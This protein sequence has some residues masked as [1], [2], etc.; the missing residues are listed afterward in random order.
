MVLLDGIDHRTRAAAIVRELVEEGDHGAGSM[1]VSLYDTA[2]VSMVSRSVHGKQEW[3]YPEAFEY[4]LRTQDQ[5]GGWHTSPFAIDS[6]LNTLAALLALCR[7]IAEADSP[8]ESIKESLFHRRNRTIY[9]LD[10]RLCQWNIEATVSDG[11]EIIVPKLL[12]LLSAEGIDFNFPGLDTLYE[13]RDTSLESFDPSLLYNTVR[14]PFAQYLE[15]LIG[16]VDFDQIMQ[17]RISGSM[18]GSPAATAA[19]L[20]N[21]TIWDSEAEAYLDGALAAADYDIP[22]KVPALFPANI[23]EVSSSLSTLLS[24]GLD[25]SHLGEGCIQ[26]L[27][28]LLEVCL[29]IEG[30]VIGVAPNLEPEAGITAKVLSTLCLLGR[31]PSAEGLIAKFDAGDHFK[32]KA[33]DLKPGFSTNCLVLKAFLELVPDCSQSERIEK[34]VRYIEHYWW[35]TNGQIEETTNLSP[36]YPTMLMVDAFTHLVDLW[37]KDQ[38]PFTHNLAVKDKVIICLYQALTRVLQIQNLDGSWGCG[39]RC[40]TTAYAI[41]TLAKLSGTSSAPSVRTQITHAIEA[42]RHFLVQNF[43]DATEPEHIWCGKTTAGSRIVS[44]AHIIAALEA[45]VSMHISRSVEIMYQMPLAKLAVHTKYFA[46]QPWFAHMQ[47]WQVQA[48]LVQSQLFLPQLKSIRHVIFPKESVQE[49]RYFETIPFVW[50]AT[51]IYRQRLVAPEYLYQMMTL[52]FLNRQLSDYL[53]HHA[54][55]TFAGC[56]SELED[57][58]HRIFEH[59]ELSEGRDGYYDSFDPSSMRSSTST[60]M[61]TALSEVHTILS[62]FVAHT[63]DH[64]YVVMA[65]ITDQAKLRSELLAFLIGKLHRES[66]KSSAASPSSDVDLSGDQT[67]HNY[68]FA[69]LSCLVGNQRASGTQ[70]APLDFLETPEQQYLASAMCKHISVINFLSSNA[71]ERSAVTRG[72]SPRPTTPG[73]QWSWNRRGQNSSISSMSTTSTYSNGGVSPASVLSSNSSAPPSVSPMS[74]HF[75]TNRSSPNS[76]SNALQFLRLLIHERRCLDVCLQDLNAAAICSRTANVIGLFSDVSDLASQVFC[77]PNIGSFQQPMTA[78]EVIEQACNLQPAPVR[79]KRSVRKGSVG[80]ARAGLT[81]E[82]PKPKHEITIKQAPPIEPPVVKI[83]VPKLNMPESKHEVPDNQTHQKPPALRD[84]PKQK[85][86]K[87]KKQ[88]MHPRFTSLQDAEYPQPRSAPATQQSFELDPSFPVPHIDPSRN[89]IEMSRIEKIMSEM[90]EGDK[91]NST[92]SSGATLKTKD[93]SHHSPQTRGRAATTGE[94]IYM[95]PS[96]RNLEAQRRLHSAPTL[97]SP[98]SEGIRMAKAR[99]HIQRNICKELDKQLEDNRKALEK[100]KQAETQRRPTGSQPQ[101]RL[102]TVKIVPTIT[103]S[104][105]PKAKVKK[106]EIQRVR[107]VGDEDEK[108]LEANGWIKSPPPE[109]PGVSFMDFDLDEE[110]RRRGKLRRKRSG[111]PKLK[112]PF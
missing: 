92:P 12:E 9:Y 44:Q 55:G 37:D 67:H 16:D 109:K 51:N 19:Y 84:P 102:S 42:G 33:E 107:F 31:A 82:V 79:S 7:H 57:I 29:S 36:T 56:L 39:R 93:G 87:Q 88:V 66:D 103:R 15:G 32:N 23:F 110:D 3:L 91:S 13:M 35:A 25:I 105:L 18:M 73:S 97:P 69:F 40:E 108:I 8:R 77:D 74:E 30:G 46:R 94:S 64:P 78:S 83:G 85:S 45:P 60:V 98:D 61:N 106:S 54:S 99:L 41:L 101:M 21:C 27:V 81:L 95:L 71:N 20:I 4:L 100:H 6:I 52:T 80:R 26:S 89:S 111:G 68:T 10:E 22:T 53:S 49:D 43:A 14:S 62:K 70:D 75:I 50:L 34:L 24:N 48:C 2:W 112:L 11:F 58:V 17:H 28:D 96:N 1:T 38:A 5:D 47:E 90:G 72:N 76:A 65:S 59:Y 63:L 104:A 86:N